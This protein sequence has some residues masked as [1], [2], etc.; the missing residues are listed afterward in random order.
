M[1]TWFYCL[2]LDLS[3]L[4][5]WSHY[6]VALGREKIKSSKIVAVVMTSLISSF[7]LKMMQITVMLIWDRTIFPIT[8]PW[9]LISQES[10]KA[11]GDPTRRCLHLFLFKVA[12]ILKCTILWRHI[13]RTCR[14]RRVERHSTLI[15]G[16]LPKTIN[17]LMVDRLRRDL[18]KFQ[19]RVSRLC[20]LLT[21]T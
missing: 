11:P 12:S 21:I 2:L 6:G 7:W 1:W 10:Q 14:V 17:W 15:R 13:D 20:L 8:T 16:T 18:E 4:F 19:E 9:T 3:V 5:W